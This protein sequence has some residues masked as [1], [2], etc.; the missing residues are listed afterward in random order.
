MKILFDVLSDPSHSHHPLP[1]IAAGQNL[2]AAGGNPHNATDTSR[3]AARRL[4]PVAGK[5]QLW[6]FMAVVSKGDYD[7]TDQE[8]QA[9]LEFSGD[10]ERPPRIGPV[11]AGLLEGSGRRS[12][13]PSGRPATVYVETQEGLD[14][15]NPSRSDAA[16][17]E[18]DPTAVTNDS[19]VTR[20]EDDERE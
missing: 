2:I 19:A 18:Q 7:A 15:A 4:R 3:E 9:D 16:A 6:L 8:V 11:K 13:S 14:I 12:N 1:S 5:Q 17:I 20:S 10:S